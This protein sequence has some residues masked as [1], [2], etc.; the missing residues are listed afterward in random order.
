MKGTTIAIPRIQQLENSA[1]EGNIES[2][3]IIRK[4]EKA[5]W[6]DG[7]DCRSGRYIRDNWFN[8]LFKKK[9]KPEN[10]V[11]YNKDY[12]NKR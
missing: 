2:I 6:E 11:Y 1:R 10:K 3:E 8:R 12:K 4:I 5:Q 7:F 9:P